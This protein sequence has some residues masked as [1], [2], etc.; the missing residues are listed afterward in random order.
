MKICP[1]IS[2]VALL[3]FLKNF[4]A[5]DGL[6]LSASTFESTGLAAGLDIGDGKTGGF[7]DEFGVFAMFA[8]FEVCA[9]FEMFALLSDFV[10]LAEWAK[11]EF[12]F[13]AEFASFALLALLAE[14]FPDIFIKKALFKFLLCSVHCLVQFSSLDFN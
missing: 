8:D 14:L 3:H 6:F 1:S 11:L 5:D 10:E 4:A 9:V 12:A 7:W 13:F 2:N